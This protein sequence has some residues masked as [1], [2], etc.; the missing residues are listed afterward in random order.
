MPYMLP[1]KMGSFRQEWSIA[2]WCF[3]ILFRYNLP[4]HV[5]QGSSMPIKQNTRGH[6]IYHSQCQLYL[7]ACKITYWSSNFALLEFSALSVNFFRW[8]GRLGRQALPASLISVGLSWAIYLFRLNPAYLEYIMWCL[9]RPRYN[10]EWPVNL[11]DA[12]SG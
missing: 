3:Q 11:I 9:N 8:S 5:T 10:L 4:R 12:S 1:S 6:K 2:V 7:S